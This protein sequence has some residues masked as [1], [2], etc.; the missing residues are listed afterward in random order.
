MKKIFDFQKV[1]NLKEKTAA[2]SKK[3]NK[4][5]TLPLIGKG[6]SIS[7]RII[8][9]FSLV[10]VSLTM[11]ILFLLARSISFSNRYNEMLSN[12]FYLNYI[13]SET[14]R[15]SARIV[16]LCYAGCEEDASEQQLIETM[17]ADIDLVYENI[18]DDS[19]YDSSRKEAESIKRSLTEYQTAYTGVLQA[20]NG[21]YSSA[22]LESA[23]QMTNISVLMGINC[24]TLLESEI[25][26]SQ[27]VQEQIQKDFTQ[28]V[29]M[30]VVMFIIILIVCIVYLFLLRRKIVHPIN[31]LK[32]KTTKVAGGDLSGSPVQIT[33]K[34]EFASLAEHFN[35]M[36]ENI[37][38]IICK[39]SEV[40]NRIND[41]S[42]LV[43]ESIEENTEMSYKISEQMEDM[44]ER[45]IVA[46]TQSQDSIEKAE[47]VSEISSHIVTR[48]NHINE[49]AKEAM[50]LASC[51]DENLHSYVEQ[52]KEV[53]TVIYEVADT[54]STLSDKATLMNSILNSITEISSQTNLL[55]L[56][57][58]IEAAR[59]GE[60][61][62]GFAVVASEIR[63]LAE[64]TSNAAA[65]IGQIVGDVQE[66]SSEM[67][68]KMKQG[69]EKLNRGN[70]LA[71]K[72]QENFRDI[73][74]GTLTVSDD[75]KDIHVELEEL[76]A[77]IQRIVEIIHSIDNT[78]QENLNV[79][80]HVTDFV[81]EETTNL[82]QVSA[83][84]E[85][86][87]ELAK[88]LDVVVSKFSL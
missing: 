16:N 68:L 52:L 84:T 58:S 13:K 31:I 85:S 9:T 27:V 49:N 65:Q 8:F 83:S 57:A 7:K 51:G 21:S 81:N 72:L 29:T 66:N 25:Q 71:D 73:M 79:A 22:G 24:N 62:R 60:A 87:S 80:T 88:E 11:I 43:N 47:A 36:F 67:N 69:I 14:N 1:K 20:G 12:V 41:S 15:Q 70:T 2:K 26:R 28:M 77:M 63:K 86:L 19:L 55:S 6:M 59:A 74:S 45:I 53:N 17:L 5:V 30:L 82:S 56:N 38:D 32:E 39:I 42:K 46:G 10:I 33:S 61:G 54:A 76:S 34:D 23:N 40:G 64:D 18:G 44:R 35:T 37:H 75:I 78:I 48:T 3:L 4:N 50:N